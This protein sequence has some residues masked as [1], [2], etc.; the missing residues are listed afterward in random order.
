MNTYNNPLNNAIDQFLN[1]S[2]NEVF[3]VSFNAS[4]PAVNISEDGETH[5][6]ELAIPGIPKEA[7]K[8]SIEDNKLII[9][10]EKSEKKETPDSF[11]RREFNYESFNRSFTI[12]TTADINKIKAKYEAGILKVS[13]A[14]KEEAIDKGPIN[15]DIS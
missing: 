4:K 9:K 7:V 5:Y 10:A 1:Q 2:L 14:K 15:I 13:I 8:M 12:P 6:L 3:G 11:T